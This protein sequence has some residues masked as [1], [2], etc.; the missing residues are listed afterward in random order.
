MYDSWKT[1][2]MLYIRGKENSVMLRDSVEH[3]PYK[4]KS[5][6]IVKDTDGV[7]DI[8]HEE[9]LEDLKGDDKLRYDSDIKAINILLL[10]LPSQ[11][12][13]GN[14]GN[15]QA[16]GAWVINAV[17]NTGANQPRVIRCYNCKGKEKPDFL[18]DSLEETDDWEDLQLQATTNF[19]VDYFDPYDLDCDDKATAI[20]IFMANL[21]LLG[22]L[23]D[24]TVTPRYDFDTLSKMIEG[25]LVLLD[26]DGKPLKPSKLTLPSSSNV[27]SK[28]VDDLVNEDNDNEVEEVYDETTT[29]MASTGIN[30]NKAS[31]S[32]SGGGNKSLY[33]Q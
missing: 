33:E 4:F 10:R 25:M 17:G 26:D 16:S 2:I 9:R 5:E 6:I 8:Y 19:K 15:N 12:Y 28:K 20:A 22:S 29:Y 30:V 18:A 21:S 24:D 1:R 27:V 7:T 32:G 11:G 31:K 13:A 23:N 3:G 14:D